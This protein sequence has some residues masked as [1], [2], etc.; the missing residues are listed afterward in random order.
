MVI[1]GLDVGTNVGCFVGNKLGTY[2]GL[3]VGS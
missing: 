2:D 3:E 1:V